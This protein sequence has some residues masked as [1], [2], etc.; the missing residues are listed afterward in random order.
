MEFARRVLDNVPVAVNLLDLET[1]RYT[2]M[3]DRQ[4][5]LTGFTLDE[6]N[7]I[8]A[9]EAYARVHPDDRAISVEQQRRIAEG[10]DPDLVVEYRWQV[11]SG[12]FRW[13]SDRRAVI[14]DAAGV[15]T[16]LVGISRDITD[17]RDA[18]DPAAAQA[19]ALAEQLEDEVR[20]RTSELLA[21][22]WRY[23]VLAESTTDIV[24]EIGHDG[25]IRWV[26]DRVRHDLGWAP[27]TLVDGPFLDL[28][29]PSDRARV[30]HELDPLNDGL[31]FDEASPHIHVRLRTHDGSFRWM[32]QRLAPVRDADGTLVSIVAGYAI[33]EDLVSERTRATTQ[34]ELLRAV[35]DAALEPQVL[36]QAVRGDD[37]RV[38]DFLYLDANM[39]ACRYLGLERVDLVGRTLRSVATE[40]LIT[41]G[42]LGHLV[43][44][45]ETA[46]PLLLDD[47]P[48]GTGVLGDDQYLDVRAQTVFGDRLSLSWRN[49]TDRHRDARALADTAAQLR[50]VA[51]QKDRFI[52]ALSHELRNPLAAMGLALWTLR[53]PDAS[54]ADPALAL[55]VMERQLSQVTRLV[56]DLLDVTRLANGRIELRPEPLDLVGILAAIA[57]DATL[58]LRAKGLTLQVTL[59]HVPMP[60]AGDRV[61]ITQAFTNLVQNA[62]KFTPT[63]GRVSLSAHMDE[64]HRTAVVT[65]EDS[66]LGMDAETLSA[67]FTPFGLPPRWS[68]D[69][70]TGLGL[71]L[72]IARDIVER[73]DGT[74]DATS[75]GPGQGSRFVVTL[76]LARTETMAP[77]PLTPSVAIAARHLRVLLIEDDSALA[78]MTAHVL[79]LLGHEPTVAANGP[80]GLALARTSPPDVVLCDIGL[81]GMTG[82]EV[83]AAMRD[84]PV[85]HAVPRIALTGFATPTD[86]EAAHDAGFD[87]HLT[88]PVGPEVLQRALWH[89][90]ALLERL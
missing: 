3:N 18:E 63:E 68:G 33:I 77:E 37:G 84:D 14:R 13:F 17:E 56:D 5:A 4:V 49:V 7:A 29:Y 51:V 80:D 64:V 72:S 30:V 75:S 21:S 78:A 61:R 86:I 57:E 70:P 31:P 76:P 67:L 28:V 6:I 55:R 48:I 73:H 34:A 83:A 66:G 74:I 1:G 2:Y 58:P 40:S 71:G 43:L 38:I 25:G 90:T 53:R 24:F 35:T 42:F 9:E 19:R 23:R 44:A 32:A 50:Q 87:L 20:R 69:R 85:L 36:M 8:S 47:F 62:A 16:H 10:L 60:I 39:A 65:V 52:S 26:S 27:E 88:K 15:P 11:K 79:H 22:E 89:C 12:E 81:P 59:P 82:L 46:E 54:D 45:L 41:S